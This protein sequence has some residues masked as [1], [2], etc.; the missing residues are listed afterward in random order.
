VEEKGHFPDGFAPVEDLG[1]VDDPILPDQKHVLAVLE[2]LKFMR[3]QLEKIGG[4]DE[5]A[6]EA[7]PV[8]KELLPRREPAEEKFPLL[9][10][11]FDDIGV[12][13]GSEEAV[14]LGRGWAKFLPSSRG[15]SL[16]RSIALPEARTLPYSPFFPSPQASGTTRW[17]LTSPPRPSFPSR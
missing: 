14:R 17:Q 8:G 2:F 1:V 15:F 11:L 16:L 13:L 4:R 5:I 6:E 12:E 9:P 7:R 3:N 10:L